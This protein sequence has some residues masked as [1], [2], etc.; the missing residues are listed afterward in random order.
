MAGAIPTAYFI[1][2]YRREG[3]RLKEQIFQPLRR[4]KPAV[5]RARLV[6][7]N[8]LPENRTYRYNYVRVNCSTRCI[9]IVEHAIGYSV[10]LG[11]PA[12]EL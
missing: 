7:I 1:E 9:D 11:A 4:R 3:R 6:E 5:S 12:G 10:Y 2:Q 8:L